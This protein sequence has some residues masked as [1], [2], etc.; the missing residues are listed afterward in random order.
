MNESPNSEL[1]RAILTISQAD[2]ITKLLQEVRVGRKRPDDPG[3][4]AI[5]ESWLTTYCQVLER[6]LT[7]DQQ[8]FIRLDPSPRLQ[9]LTEAGVLH[10]DHPAARKLQAT[11]DQKRA[12]VT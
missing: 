12:R 11:F 4:R 3:L 1:Q 7:L 10:S 8:E 6:C 2:P 5:T 9:I